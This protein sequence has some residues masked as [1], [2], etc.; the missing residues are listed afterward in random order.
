MSHTRNDINKGDYSIKDND[1]S[2]EIELKEGHVEAF[3]TE[4]QGERRAQEDEV[5]VGSLV[6]FEQLSER[7]RQF[8]LNNTISVLQQEI[9]E[10]NLWSGSTASVVIS[11]KDSV[12]LINIGD[13]TAFLAAQNELHPLYKRLHNCSQPDVDP[14]LTLVKDIFGGWRLESGINLYKALGDFQHERYGLTHQPDIESELISKDKKYFV[15]NACD[16]LTERMSKQQ[17]DNIVKRIVTSGSILTEK[18]YLVIFNNELIKST[19]AYTLTSKL[20]AMSSQKVGDLETARILSTTLTALGY[21][22]GSRDNISVAVM[23]I[24][25][26]NPIARYVAVFDGH[27]GREVSDYLSQNFDRVIKT[28]IL[29][30]LTFE[31]SC[32]FYKNGFQMSV[33]QFDKLYNLHLEISKYIK[34]LDHFACS[35]ITDNF[36]K[37]VKKITNSIYGMEKKPENRQR[38]LSEYDYFYRFFLNIYQELITVLQLYKNCQSVIEEKTDNASI[39]KKITLYKKL[40]NGLMDRYCESILKKWEMRNETSAYECIKYE[41]LDLK[42]D[43]SLSFVNYLLGTNQNEQYGEWLEKQ[44]L[45]LLGAKWSDR[46]FIVKYICDNF[47]DIIELRCRISVDELKNYLV[48]RGEI[49]QKIDALRARQVGQD[50]ID[51]MHNEFVS[52]KKVLLNNENKYQLLSECDHALATL[53]ACQ[54][55]Y[56]KITEMRISL[57]C[58]SSREEKLPAAVTETMNSTSQQAEELKQLFAKHISQIFKRQ[59]FPKTADMK[60]H[61]SVVLGTVNTEYYD[62]VQTLFIKYVE[63]Y[64]QRERKKMFSHATMSRYGLWLEEKLADWIFSDDC[65][66]AGIGSGGYRPVETRG[67]NYLFDYMGK[68]FPSI[69]KCVEALPEQEDSQRRA[70]VKKVLDKLRC[71]TPAQISRLEQGQNKVSK[72]AL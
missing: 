57:T 1:Y 2:K 17:L 12:Y 6:E 51:I 58:F 27:S 43:L 14:H 61:L 35:E 64:I 20:L 11:C 15:I 41:I 68:V 34:K 44:I 22:L 18:D 8:V 36:K 62:I 63:Q 46:D 28:E 38:F 37:I 29:L 49:K 45:M 5:I 24:E 32:K 65:R 67:S 70:N 25:Q 7:G 42:I 71:A 66:L 40:K 9:K 50:V 21:V 33:E 16:G 69:I 47:P 39:Q 26:D 3:L 4:I 30:R 48:R 13:S 56:S 52:R 60:E 23:L 10:N 31:K 72:L 54:D 59:P 55:V 53:K 19:E